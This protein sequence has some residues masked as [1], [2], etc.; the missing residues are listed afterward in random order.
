MLKRVARLYRTAKHLRASQLA[1]RARLRLWKPPPQLAAAPPRRTPRAPLV[2]GARHA[3]SMLA[4]DEFSFI[5]ER[6]RIAAAGD[7]SNPNWP[8]LWLYNLHYFDDLNAVDAP[9]RAAWH[10]EWIERWLADNLPGRGV[11]WEPYPTSRRILSW[12]KFALR[13]GPLTPSALHSLAVQARWLQRRLEWHLGGNH[14]LANALA[15][16]CAGAFFEGPEADAWLRH[17][18]GLIERELA[19]QILADGGHYERSPMYHALVLEDLLDACNVLQCCGLQIAADWGSCALR[20]QRWLEVLTH[21]DGDIAFFNDATFGVAA[22][23]AELRAYGA[24]LLG[25]PAA[26]PA[27]GSVLLPASGYGRLQRADAVLFA[28]CAA[29]GPDHLPGHA[30]ADTLSFELSLGCERVLVNSGVS[31]YAAG[32]ERDRQRGTAA[33]NTLVIDGA[34]SSE[35]WHAFRVGRRARVVEIG[36]ED[37]ATASLLRAA[38]DGYRALE[39]RNLHRRSWRL[40]ADEVQIEDEVRGT[41][42]SAIAHFHLHPR[43]RLEGSPPNLVCV[44]PAGRRLHW[45]FSEA[46]VVEAY[47]SSWHPGFG[48]TLAATALRVRAQGGRLRT[49]I[50]WE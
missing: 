10:G 4:A 49:T 30:H 16:V 35:V 14:L 25:A 6:H 1:A 31:L 29:L 18:R 19:A 24:R 13:G 20:M 5:G 17:A 21:P 9:A 11:G 39:G 3:A 40:Q 42:G 32:A 28:D 12:I 22:L 50:A 37:E 26:A 48:S 38:H 23:P 2:P 41:H 15:L 46:A 43:V 44:T 27:L 47:D 7:W 36:F 45:R 34:D 33:H 8:R